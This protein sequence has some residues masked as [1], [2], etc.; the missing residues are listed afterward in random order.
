MYHPYRAI[1]VEI[2]NL[3]QKC[4][5]PEGRREQEKERDMPRGRGRRHHRC[6]RRKMPPLLLLPEEDAVATASA[7]VCQW[8]SALGLTCGYLLIKLH[9]CQLKV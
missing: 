9:D 6:H 3:G 4:K 7:V 2:T 8:V 5:V 1:Q